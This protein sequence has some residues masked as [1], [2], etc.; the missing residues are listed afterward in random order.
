MQTPLWWGGT[1][2]AGCG[3]LAFLQETPNWLRFQIVNG[4]LWAEHNNPP[5]KGHYPAEYGRGWLSAKGRI[6]YA[7]LALMDVL[8]TYPGGLEGS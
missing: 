4:S 3:G 6:P 5:A 1:N 2:G 8:R 7:L